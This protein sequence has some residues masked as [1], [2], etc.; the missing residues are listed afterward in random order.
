MV[1]G[2]QFTARVRRQKRS[3]DRDATEQV[4]ER[5]L[6]E[7][8]SAQVG[9]ARDAEEGEGA[10]LRGDDREHDRAPGQGPAPEEIVAAAA[11]AA[12][13]PGAPQ[14]DAR[15]VEDEDGEVDRGR[16]SAPHVLLFAGRA[17]L[18]ERSCAS[19]PN[20]LVGTAGFSSRWPSR[21]TTKASMA[22]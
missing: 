1:G 21:S 20:E 22:K 4:P 2:D 7:P 15:Q 13:Q 12:T 19:A 11:L 5:Q 18:V 17:A 14:R 6:Q 9:D 16:S 8:E 3:R 10:R